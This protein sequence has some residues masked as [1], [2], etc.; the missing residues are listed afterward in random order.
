MVKY[1]DDFYKNNL[2]IKFNQNILNIQKQNQTFI[3]KTD[4]NTFKCDKLILASGYSKF[5]K[6]NG[7]PNIINYSDLSL[8][9]DKFKNKRVLIV[10]GR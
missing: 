3:I 4:N 1:L 5:N 9:K 6:I 8:N 10:G 7:L 2:N